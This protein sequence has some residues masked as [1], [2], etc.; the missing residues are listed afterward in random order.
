[1]IIIYYSLLLLIIYIIDIM[2][3]IF[4]L[5]SYYHNLGSFTERITF[6]TNAR[7]VKSAETDSGPFYNEHQMVFL[8]GLFSDNKRISVRNAQNFLRQLRWFLRF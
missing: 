7:F 4:I 6:H 8:I 2:I 1:M 3:E 5:F